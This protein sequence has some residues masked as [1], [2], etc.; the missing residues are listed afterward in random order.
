MSALRSI[1]GSRRLR[2]RRATPAAGTSQ[3]YLISNTSTEEF[4][5]TIARLVATD[6]ELLLAPEL[7]DRLEVADGD[8]VRVTP[9]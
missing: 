9:L 4:R 5:A 3:T 7:A 8:D 6:D 1:A 2:V